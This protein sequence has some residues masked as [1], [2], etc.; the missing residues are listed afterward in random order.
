MLDGA[1]QVSRQAVQL[2]PN[3]PLALAAAGQ[4]AYLVHQYPLAE[5]YYSRALTLAP[6]R[7]DELYYLGM[8]RIQTGRFSDALAVLQKGNALWPNSP[9]YHL[10]MGK[11]LA[12]MGQWSAAREEYKLELA[13][14]PDSPGAKAGLAEAAN[15]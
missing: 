12:G 13:L 9:G 15:K 7:V 1:F 11:A 14:N 5:E 2:D 8:T 6:P 3:S 4:A 10:A